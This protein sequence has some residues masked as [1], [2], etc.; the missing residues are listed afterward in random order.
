MKIIN[1]SKYLD[2]LILIF[3]I[4]PVIPNI[5]KGLPVILLFLGGLFFIKKSNVNWKWL[6]VNS[7]LFLV[8]A[9]STI[10]S[11][12]YSESFKKL[13]TALSI[14]IIPISFFCFLSHY[15]ITELLK[16]I[17][18]KAFVISTTLFSIISFLY[19]YFN[20]SLLGYKWTTDKY[21]NI[22]M[23]MP[24]IGQHPIYCSIFLS[25][26]IIFVIYLFKKGLLKKYNEKMFFSTLTIINSIL[27]L[28]LLSKGAILS[29]FIIIFFFIIFQKINIVYKNVLIVTMVL[30]IIILFI[31]NRRMNELINTQTYETF[32]P[33][34]STSI[35]LGIYDCSIEIIKKH[36]FLGY[37]VGDAQRELNLCYANKSDILLMHKFNSHNQYLDVTIKTGFIGL[38]VFLGFLIINFIYAIKNKN[39]L[40][41]MILVLYCMMFLVENIL[42]RQS[43]VILFFFLISFFNNSKK[44]FIKN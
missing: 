41:I 19:I 8:Y 25:L 18:I 30:S 14:L 21:R 11:I 16:L 27:L 36:F 9:I 7:S 28:F 44:L 23:D 5:I 39:E 35:R 17:F 12:D 38:S 13:E 32:N 34:L 22:I 20:N 4:F 29:L 1:R 15:T 37:G 24:V 42:S 26:A 33:N 3:A 40:M 10:Y 6:L 43:G 2:G 31:Y